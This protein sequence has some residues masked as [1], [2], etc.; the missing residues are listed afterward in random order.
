[1]RANDRLPDSYHFPWVTPSGGHVLDLESS[2]HKRWMLTSWQENPEREEKVGQSERNRG[3]EKRGERGRG[4]IQAW[5]SKAFERPPTQP[6]IY[7]H[8]SHY[9]RCR[10]SSAALKDWR[11]SPLK[12]K[13]SSICSRFIYNNAK[14]WKHSGLHKQED[15][16][17]KSGIFTG[18]NTMQL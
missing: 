12:Q 3:R 10:I 9:L 1:M 18:L 7:Q 4:R 2:L 17:R 15:V 16:Q 14:L 8:P 6:R 13:C 5:D 11:E